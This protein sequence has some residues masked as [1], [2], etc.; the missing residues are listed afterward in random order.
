MKLVKKTERL[1]KELESKSG[2]FW[3][4]ICHYIIPILLYSSFGKFTIIL[5]L[6]KCSNV[7]LVT[8]HLGKRQCSEKCDLRGS[9]RVVR[10]TF[11]VTANCELDVVAWLVN[12]TDI[13]LNETIVQM[14]RSVTTS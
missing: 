1:C 13:S 14:F 7:S 4:N 9:G 5:T 8:S 6:I 3:L 2:D 12:R 11:S 10:E